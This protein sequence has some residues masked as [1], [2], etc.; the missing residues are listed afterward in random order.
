M[1]PPSSSGP[2]DVRSAAELVARHAG[3]AIAPP[4]QD[5]LVEQAGGNALALVELPVSLSQAQLA[6]EEPLPE[7]L[8]LTRDVQRLFLERV[9]RLPEPTQVLLLVIAADD[10][11]MLSTIV[12]AAGSLGVH[13]RRAGARGA[14]RRRLRQRDVAGAQAPAR[15]IRRLPAGRVG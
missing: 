11:G 12:R 3:G 8:P 10:N 9:E 2:L 6:G 1:S 4:V 15:P 13:G 5:L 14:G 7:T